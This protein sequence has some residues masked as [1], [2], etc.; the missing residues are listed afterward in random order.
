MDARWECVFL[1][2]HGQTEWNL[3]RRMQGQFDSALT[4]VGVSR[5]RHLAAVLR[6]HGVDAVFASPLGRAVATARIIAAGL[7]LPVTVVDELSEVHHGRFA[8]LT[9]DDVRDRWPDEWNSRASQKYTWTFPGG[10]SY[11]DADVRAGHALTRISGSAARRPLVVSH[12]MIGRMLQRHLLGLSAPEAL[13]CTQPNDVV[14]RIDPAAKVRQ[15][16]R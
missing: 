8:G 3:Q 11:A 9:V 15:A 4:D 1:A 2:R 7:D 14:Y 5:A 10:E 16:V 13:A 12:E 6:P